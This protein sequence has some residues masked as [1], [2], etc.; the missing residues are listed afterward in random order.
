MDP[1]GSFSIHR[2]QQQQFDLDR[3]VCIASYPIGE[4]YL[5]PYDRGQWEALYDYWVAEFL[6]C[7]ASNGFEVADPPTKETFL[8]APEAWHPVGDRGLRD[9]LSAAEAQGRISSS[10]EFLAEVCSVSPGESVLYPEQ[11]T[12]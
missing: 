2:S 11:S 8:A 6:P 3:Y 7:L 1:D 4:I 5:E 9:Q 12:P 10:N